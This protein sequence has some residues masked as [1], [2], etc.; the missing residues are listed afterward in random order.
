MCGARNLNRIARE[1]A[2]AGALVRPSATPHR[3][4]TVPDDRLR[5]SDAERDAAAGELQVHAAAGRL[6]VDELD[7]RMSAVLT[8][9]TRADIAGVM[10]DLPATPSSPIGPAPP[11]DHGFN[12]YFAVMVVLVAIWLLS[13]GGHFWPLYPALGWGLPLLLS[14]RSTAAAPARLAPASESGPR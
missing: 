1:D 3:S 10:G 5:A 9:R 13:G 6:D 2:S 11:S 4:V 7:A 8:A 14:R 12:P